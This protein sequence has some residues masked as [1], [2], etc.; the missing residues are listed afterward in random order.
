MSHKQSFTQH[1][2]RMFRLESS[3][4]RGKPYAWLIQYAY[5]QSCLLRLT[6][7]HFDAHARCARVFGKFCERNIT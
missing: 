4:I 3:G 1:F 7:F 6:A 5:P 2:W